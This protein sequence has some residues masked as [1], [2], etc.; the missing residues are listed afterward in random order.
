VK[1]TDKSDTKGPRL[2]YSNKLT[3]SKQ[4]WTGTHNSIA[5]YTYS[6]IEVYLTVPVFEA[7]WRRV[8]RSLLNNES[9]RMSKELVM[10]YFEVEILLMHM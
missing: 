8:I 7:V 6:C 3:V 9:D 2:A 4:A 5:C 1:V 10:T